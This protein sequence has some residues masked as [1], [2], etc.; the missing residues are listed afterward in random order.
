MSGESVGG[1][2]SKTSTAAPAT[3]PL[4]IASASAF[5]SMIPPRAQLINRTP[6]FIVAMVFAL[7]MWRVS[8]IS[9][10][11]T[12]MTSARRKRSSSETSSTPIFAALSLLMKGS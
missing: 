12:V 9:G 11:W 1:S 8:L 6:S 10:V 2:D 3:L 7:T 4:A 5:S